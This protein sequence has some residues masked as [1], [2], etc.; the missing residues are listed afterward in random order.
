MQFIKS[1]NLKP[2]PDPTKLVFG[3][4]LTDY[5]LEM[6]YENGKWGE[7]KLLPVHD[8]SLSP[9]SMVF[10]YG[11][12]I[13]EGCKAYRNDKDQVT[14]FRLKDNLRR[15]NLSAQRLAMPA[16][17]VD[18]VFEAIYQLVKTDREW[19]P[20]LPQTSLYLRPTMIAT[21]PSIGLKTCLNF[22]FFVVCSPVGAYQD[23]GYKP[24]R[25]FIEDQYVRAAVGG[26]GESKCGGNYAGSFLAQNLA[27]EKGF[28]QVAWLDAKERKYFEEVGAMNLY[29]VFD[30]EI[31][32]PKLTGSILKGIT[33]DS[34]LQILR[35][36]GLNVVERQL[37]VE[38]VFQASKKGT[39]REVFGCGT[40]AVV[41]A[42]GYMEYKGE[43]I[44]IN[45]GKVGALTANIFD[46]VT[47][48]QTKKVADE[49]GWVTDVK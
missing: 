41:T 4:V 32:T 31:V 18:A 25:I 48:M 2:K 24:F 16:I 17:D 20:T 36:R 46:T 49:F 30:N 44:T 11:Q 13:F 3:K 9:A 26:T 43:G 6:D 29:F 38:E 45:E 34:I 42:V 37:S 10:H 47:G 5:M 19:I 14:L 27:R 7:M 35:K 40:A 21:E 33:R 39:L 8:F 22:K 28:N 12:E 15:F 23:A 1:T